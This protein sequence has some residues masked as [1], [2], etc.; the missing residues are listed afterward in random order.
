MG[1]E[2]ICCRNSGCGGDVLG[3]ERGEGGICLD[4]S[5]GW[6]CVRGRK[7][8]AFGLKDGRGGR[9]GTL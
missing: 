1:L 5:G 9:G 4:G 8:G 3:A 7:I 6:L 2:L